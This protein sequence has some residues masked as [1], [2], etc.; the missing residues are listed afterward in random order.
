[1][2]T[3]TFKNY[4]YESNNLSKMTLFAPMIKLVFLKIIT[5]TMKK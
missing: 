4:Q 2:N 3:K 5:F 1:M